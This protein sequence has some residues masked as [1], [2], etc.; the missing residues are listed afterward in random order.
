MRPLMGAPLTKSKRGDL[1]VNHGGD[2]APQL[3]DW[4]GGR[5]GGLFEPCSPLMIPTEGQGKRAALLSA[6]IFGIHKFL[7]GGGLP[8]VFLNCVSTPETS[9][10]PFGRSLLRRQFSEHDP[11][12]GEVVWCHFHMNT[13]ANNRADTIFAHFAGCI[14]NHPVSVVE[15]YAETSVGQDFLDLPCH[16]K[17]FFFRHLD[18]SMQRESAAVR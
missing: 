11:A 12:L 3:M 2:E 17:K 9:T 6:G 14:G 18:S 5:G 1:S 13:V 4:N 15:Q 16:G 8:P 10:L 7:V